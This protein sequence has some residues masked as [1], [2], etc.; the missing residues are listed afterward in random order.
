MPDDTSP[1]LPHWRFWLPLAFQVVLVLA[2][3]AR[4]AYTYWSGQTAFLRVGPVDPYE[5]L[6]GYSQTLNLAI[7]RRSQL[8]DL[9]GWEQLLA[10]SRS[11][12]DPERLAVGTAFYVILEAPEQERQAWTPVA[13][14]AQRPSSLP[15]DRIALRGRQKR[16]DIDY[17]LDRY[18]LPEAQREAIN[19]RIRELAP[20]E[21]ILLQVKVDRRGHAVPVRLWVGD[22]GYRF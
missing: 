9:S 13:V 16:Y 18:Y 20:S 17:G 7:S 1:R 8:Q 5:L 4:S 11:D 21:W 6:R 10:Q 15:A 14:R 22:R 2:V 12:R 3:P 19:E